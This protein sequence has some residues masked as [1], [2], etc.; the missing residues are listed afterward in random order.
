VGAEKPMVGEFLL[1]VSQ[2]R[3]DSPLNP[4]RGYRLSASL[5]YASPNLGGEVGF[6]HLELAASGHLP[7]GAGRWIHVGVRHGVAAT[8]NRPADNLPFARRFFPG[9]ENSVRGFKEGEASPRDDQG[10][11]IGAET[12]LSGSVE[13][14]QA[15]TPKWSLVAFVDGVDFAADLGD[16]PGNEQLYS[17]GGGIRW[18]TIIGPL[19]L[20]YG[21]NLN[22]RPQDPVGTLL[23]SL[24]CPF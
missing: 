10:N 2:D 14:E 23:F 9:G 11:Y 19:R 8:W 18:K 3:R 16:Y 13:L 1:D 20:E 15:I 4:Q 12:Y 7:L 22:P 6:Q 24:G 17:A 21:Y 5:E